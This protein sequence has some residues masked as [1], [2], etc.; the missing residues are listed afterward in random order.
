M[1]IYIYTFFFFL[2]T[3]FNIAYNKYVVSYQLQS[4]VLLLGLGNHIK[5]KFWKISMPLNK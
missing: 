4:R 1:K 2:Q 5:F 3:T